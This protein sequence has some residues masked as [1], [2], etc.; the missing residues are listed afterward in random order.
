M[1]QNKKVLII[2]PAFSEYERALKVAGVD[3]DIFFLNESDD[4]RV[5]IEKLAEKLAEGFN[6]LWMANPAN[7]NGGLLKKAVM[8]YNDGALKRHFTKMMGGE[9]GDTE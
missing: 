2:V 7:P 8:E 1:L 9:G 5:D 3:V 4:F 6:T